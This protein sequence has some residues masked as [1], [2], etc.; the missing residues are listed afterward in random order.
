MNE[1]IG[2]WKYFLR[3][4]IDV[5]AYCQVYFGIKWARIVEVVMQK[6]DVF[7]HLLKQPRFQLRLRLGFYLGL[8]NVTW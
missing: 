1:V 3:S 6:K 7:V 4:E 8:A 2:A 5:C